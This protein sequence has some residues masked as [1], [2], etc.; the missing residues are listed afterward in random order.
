MSSIR[1]ASFGAATVP[2]SKIV[3]DKPLEMGQYPIIANVLKA[4]YRLEELETVEL[5]WGDVAPSEVVIEEQKSFS[6]NGTTI[7]ILTAES[8]IEVRVRVTV[9]SGAALRTNAAVRINE[10][11]VFSLSGLTVGSSATTPPLILNPGDVLTAYLASGTVGGSSARVE[12]IYTGR[13]VGAKTFDLAGKWLALGLDMKGLAATVKIQGM[14][15]PYSD[16]VYCFP[17]APTELKIP[18]DWDRS[19][20]R[21]VIKVYK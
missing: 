10:V 8:Q 4:P 13:F 5:D 7:N 16:Y 17:I 11:D 15:I 12:L 9:L 6:S 3:V 20:E 14:E 2:L 18:G 19:Q 1:F 21:P